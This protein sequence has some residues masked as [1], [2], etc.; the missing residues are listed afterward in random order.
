M[1]DRRGDDCPH[2]GNA[3]AIARDSEFATVFMNAIT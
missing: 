1:K 3:P 2:Y